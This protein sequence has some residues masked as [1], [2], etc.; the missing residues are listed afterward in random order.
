MAKQQERKLHESTSRLFCQLAFLLLAFLPLACCVV[1]CTAQR[2]SAYH[3]FVNSYYEDRVY[4]T[5]GLKVRIDRVIPMAPNRST[6]LGVRLCNPETEEVVFEA[7]AMQVERYRGQCMIDGVKGARLDAKQFA[8]A[9]P[10]INKVF[11]EQKLEGENAPIL[12]IQELEIISSHHEHRL[13]DIKLAVLPDLD[14]NLTFLKLSCQLAGRIGIGDEQ[15]PLQLIVERCHE[16]GRLATKARISTGAQ[17]VP[18]NILFDYWPEL[19]TLGLDAKLFG[20]AMLETKQNEWSLRV[21]PNDSSETRLHAEPLSVLDVDFSRLSW[22]TGFEIQG[23]GKL[24]IQ[25]GV[26]GNSGLERVTGYAIVNDGDVSKATLLSLRDNLGLQLANAIA[27]S[28][29]PDIKFHTVF[30]RFRIEPGMIQLAGYQ[31]P[32]DQQ[33]QDQQPQD[34]QP[35]QGGGVLWT[36]QNPQPKLLAAFP[37]QQLSTQF[38]LSSLIAAMKSTRSMGGFGSTLSNRARKIA[39]L[40]PV[41]AEVLA[42]HGLR[43]G[44]SNP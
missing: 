2:F 1:Y 34:Q 20:I 36:K 8:L 29:L 23:T 43:I 35:G 25:S 4:E 40:L 26:L 31:Q 9:W 22:S 27:Y 13:E 7:S 12:G 37:A 33:P 24:A 41:T 42:D 3:S 16:P 11:L 6:V 18:C 15:N 30:C 21:E 10:H 5:L 44:R 14:K 28:Q 19:A 38:P 17:P 39:G 32:Q